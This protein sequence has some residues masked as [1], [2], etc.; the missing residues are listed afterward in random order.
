MPNYFWRHCNDLIFYDKNILYLGN[1]RILIKKTCFKK[2]FSNNSPSTVF[3]MV[4][5][6]FVYSVMF[7][8]FPKK[9]KSISLD[10]L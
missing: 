1:L 4:S 3:F 10:N 9:D 6:I 8:A 5:K 2:D 7:C